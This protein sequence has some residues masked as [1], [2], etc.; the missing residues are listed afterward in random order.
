MGVIVVNIFLFGCY[1]ILVDFMLVLLFIVLM[2]LFIFWI[3][4]GF[5]VVME[6]M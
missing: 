4:L 1:L 5:F 3:N 6:Y 2:M